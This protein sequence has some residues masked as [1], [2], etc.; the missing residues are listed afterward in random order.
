MFTLNHTTLQSAVLEP[1]LN[2]NQTRGS[3]AVIFYYKKREK[4]GFWLQRLADW[5]ERILGSLK[6]VYIALRDKKSVCV[7]LVT[8]SIILYLVPGD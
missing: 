6:H 2:V 8:S 3:K 5:W 7:L 4:Y 1:S